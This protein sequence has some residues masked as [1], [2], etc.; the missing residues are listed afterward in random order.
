MDKQY[1]IEVS[2]TKAKY[3]LLE[4]TTAGKTAFLD[5]SIAALLVHS[6]FTIMGVNINRTSTTS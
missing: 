2:E 5:Y 6:Y 4:Q 1:Y 3:I